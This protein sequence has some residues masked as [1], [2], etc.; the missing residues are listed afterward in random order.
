M[1]PMITCWLNV[2]SPLNDMAPSARFVLSPKTVSVA[3]TTTIRN[4]PDIVSSSKI[5][6]KE[7]G[8]A[9]E[10]VRARQDNAAIVSD[11]AKKVKYF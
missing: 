7:G 3:R 2:V 4:P 11:I 5:A 8:G 9:E 10:L 6:G 1:F